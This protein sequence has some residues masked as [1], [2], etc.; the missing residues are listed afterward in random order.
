MQ[1]DDLKALRKRAGLSQDQ[2]A[3]EIGVSRVL[4]GLM[5]RGQSPITIATTIRLM[6]MAAK[7]GIDPRPDQEIS[8]ANRFKEVL[9]EILDRNG[10]RVPTEEEL[11][12]DARELLRSLREPTHAM[13]NASAKIDLAGIPMGGLSYWPAMIDA[14]IEDQ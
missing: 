6:Q 1:P 3:D 14:A 12:E 9:L 8:D 4:V 13:R 7:L 5:E 10:A 11:A 2:L